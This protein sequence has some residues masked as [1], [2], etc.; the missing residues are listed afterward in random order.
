MIHMIMIQVCDIS[1]E[2]FKGARWLVL[3][4]CTIVTAHKKEPVS[5]CCEVL[6]TLHSNCLWFVSKLVCSDSVGF[7]SFQMVTL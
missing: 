3:G 2:G 5:L 1:K 4:A 7:Y 6:K